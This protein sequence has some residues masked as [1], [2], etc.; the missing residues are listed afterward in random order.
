[1]KRQHTYTDY[2]Q[3]NK[4]PAKRPS[5][6]VTRLPPKL[7]LTVPS[8]PKRQPR[9]PTRHIDYVTEPKSKLSKLD[10]K[11]P[12]DI[13]VVCPQNLHKEPEDKLIPCQQKLPKEPGNIPN[14]PFHQQLFKDPFFLPIK[15]PNPPA[16]SV[17]VRPSLS[18]TMQ[19]PKRADKPPP[20]P[21]PP[22]RPPPYNIS[23]VSPS[24]LRNK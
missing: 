24:D 9:E 23:M 21:P 15:P 7:P 19:K 20:P 13:L 17:K 11:L 16:Q 14:Q 3:Y 1:M 12:R 4:R 18:Q 2:V 10:S 6:A 5:A 8:L 22:A